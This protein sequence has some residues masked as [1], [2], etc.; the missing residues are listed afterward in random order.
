MLFRDIYTALGLIG[1][2]YIFAGEMLH[3]VDFT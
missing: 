3:M 2:Y 1:I